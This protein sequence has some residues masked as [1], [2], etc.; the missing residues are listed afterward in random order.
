MDLEAN[1]EEIKTEGVHEEVPKE[2]STVKTVIALKRQHGDWHLAVRCCDQPKKQTQRNC[3]SGKKLAAA[4]RG[5]TCRPIPAWRKGH[6]CQ[7]SGQDNVTRRA[8][9]GQSFERRQ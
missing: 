4:C 1:A 7:G 9:K 8:P 5:M 2:K 6:S 3:G